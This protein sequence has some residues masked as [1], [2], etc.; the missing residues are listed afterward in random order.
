MCLLVQMLPG[1]ISTPYRILKYSTRAGTDT[2][3]NID[4][5][6]ISQ[7]FTI[8]S[9]DSGQQYIPPFDIEVDQTALLHRQHR[10]KCSVH[11]I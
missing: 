4:G 11:A 10:H 5:K 9:F 2:A 6:K 8:T 7:N 1:S 3:Q